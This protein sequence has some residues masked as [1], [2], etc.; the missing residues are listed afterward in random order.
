MTRSVIILVLAMSA[1]A[2]ATWARQLKGGVDDVRT[3]EVVASRF[4]FEPPIISVTEGERVRLHLRSIDRT[5]GIGIKGF[6]VAA[7]IPKAGEVVNV[8]FVADRTGTFDI[9]CSEYCGTGHA[10]MKGRLIVL[11]REK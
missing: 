7:L 11:A 5:H 4:K 3:I 9:T 2:A 6:G 10:A 8:E 1:T